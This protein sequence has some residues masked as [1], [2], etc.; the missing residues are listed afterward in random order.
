[1]NPAASKRLRVIGADLGCIRLI[2]KVLGIVWEVTQELKLQFY[3]DW[4]KLQNF[5]LKVRQQCLT[6][7]DQSQGRR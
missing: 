4:Y 2:F 6:F 1:M 3:L 7:G 5:T